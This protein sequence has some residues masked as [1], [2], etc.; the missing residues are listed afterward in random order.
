MIEILRMLG[1]IVSRKCAPAVPREHDTGPVSL[2]LLAPRT[3]R[4]QLEQAFRDAGL[5]VTTMDSWD[6]AMAAL[7]GEPMPVVLYDAGRADRPWRQAI[8]ELSATATKPAVV[9]LSER[10]DPNLKSE[11][12]RSGGYDV[13]RTPVDGRCA[14]VIVR[15]GWLFWRN[16]NALRAALASRS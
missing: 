16:Q 7:A 13:L 5:R 8:E 6:E 4:G 3:D 14:S 11:T 1:R 2:A 12:V 15:S 9:L 10:V